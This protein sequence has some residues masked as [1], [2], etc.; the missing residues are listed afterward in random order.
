M[1]HSRV[2]ASATQIL[3]FTE[4]FVNNTIKVPYKK[5]DRSYEVYTRDVW[6]HI[7]K[8][9][10]NPLLAPYIHYDAVRMYRYKN[11]RF[12]RFVS[13]PHTADRMWELQVL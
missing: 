7:L 2:A 13:G 12:V 11:G 6:Q 3:I 1:P 5:K 10:K 8:Q 4:Q 9:I